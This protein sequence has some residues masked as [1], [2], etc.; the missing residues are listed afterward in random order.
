MLLEQKGLFELLG[1][2]NN[3]VNTG[4]AYRGYDLQ[5]SVSNAYISII[6]TNQSVKKLMF[7]R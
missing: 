5:D 3:N 6:L 4:I 7:I 2:L 1:F